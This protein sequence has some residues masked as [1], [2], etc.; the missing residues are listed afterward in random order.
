MTLYVG[1]LFLLLFFVV[2]YLEVIALLWSAVV[3]YA[4]LLFS[5]QPSFY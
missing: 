4:A 3:F 1:V 5:V 2:F